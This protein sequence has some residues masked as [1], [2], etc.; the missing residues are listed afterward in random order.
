MDE[1]ANMNDDDIHPRV[2]E[3]LARR[4]IDPASLEDPPAHGFDMIQFRTGQ[5]HTLLSRIIPT[6]FAHAK[7]DHPKVAKWADDYL[8]DPDGASSLVLVGPTG[9]GKTHQGWGAVRAIA[10]GLAAT[11]RGLAWR[12]TTHPDLNA[13]LRPK[14]DGS[15]TWALEPYME[16]ELLL[17]D[18]L[19]AGKQTDWTGDT[20]YRL[21]DH[22]WANRKTTI[23]STNLTPNA[24]TDAV[25]DRVVSRLADAVR[26]T[27]KGSDRRWKD[28]A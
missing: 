16:A 7:V 17:L 6:R 8:N 25:G 28:A 11:G 21:V 27:I 19:G 10:E 13:A 1:S 15:H 3:F 20:L 9:V 18:D 4:G 24:L 23:Y 14:P 5:A 26:V 2:A 22:R 12:A